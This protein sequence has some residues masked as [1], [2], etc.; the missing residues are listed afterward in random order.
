[1][2]KRLDKEIEDVLAVHRGLS[3]KPAA[4]DHRL[5][6]GV[7]AF[8][9]A[10]AD[11]E[12]ITASF[13]IEI[14]IPHTYP[15]ELPLVRETGFQIDDAYEHIYADRALCLAVPIEERRVFMEKPSLSGFIERLVVPYL[16]GYCYWEKYGVHPFGEQR[17]GLEGIVEHYMELLALADE[18]RLLAMMAYLVEFGYRGH[19]PCPCGSQ[20]SVRACHGAVL[21]KL[22]ARHTRA[23]LER[24]F[25]VTLTDFHNRLEANECRISQPLA[26]QVLRIIGKKRTRQARGG[27][28]C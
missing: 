12:S 26:R 27:R 20:R 13:E 17:H 5:L 8:E 21:R 28:E 23:S 19:H 14:L 2:G 6:S 3:E 7:L 15:D 11:L 18:E 9:A 22:Y 24:D 10:P 4:A 16:Y 25:M 1:M